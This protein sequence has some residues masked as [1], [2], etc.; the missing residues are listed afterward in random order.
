MCIRAKMYIGEMYCESRKKVACNHIVPLVIKNSRDTKTY[1]N[2]ARSVWQ[3]VNLAFHFD[4][5]GYPEKATIDERQFPNGRNI[6]RETRFFVRLFLT[7]QRE[8]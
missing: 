4:L 5:G 1:S 3:N 8:Y 6:F 7:K 2:N